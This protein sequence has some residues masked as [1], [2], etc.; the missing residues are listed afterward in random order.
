M[1]FRTLTTALLAATLALTP[2]YTFSDVSGNELPDFGDSSGSL[3]TPAQEQELGKAFMRSIRSQATLVSDPWINAYI[4]QLGARLVAASDAPSYPFTFFV[5]ADPSI[6]AFA[7]PGGYIGIH[8][9]LILAARNESELAGVMAH[10]IAHVTQRHLLR[11]YES[12]S[13]MSLPT[14]AGMLA[15]LLLGVATKDAGAGIAAA[16]AVQAGNIQHQLNFTRANEKEADRIG[17]QTL[18]RSGIDPFGMPSFFERLHQSTR[19]YG[20]NVPEFL[21]THPVTSNRIAE[22]MSRAEK[23]GRGK[24]RDSLE[25]D[26]EQARLKVLTAKDPQLVLREYRALAA[27]GDDSAAV[28]YALALANW[29]TGAPDKAKKLLR[30]LLKE[31]PDRSLY[32]TTLAEI[33]LETGQKQAALRRL[34]D[35]LS[36]YPGDLV[37][38]QYYASALIQ[39]GHA[40]QARKQLLA[41]L[42]NRNAR[43]T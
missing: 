21:S 17:I 34:R 40:D 27:K 20:N 26:L 41:M 19:L 38:G 2:P 32:R 31:D 22:A 18:G 36:L 33:E 8:T 15:A 7:G 23:I 35:T 14:A 42:R 13:Q 30:S 1:R 24:E 28:R 16:S 11:A 43:T 25:F 39:T 10:E 12:A 6:N 5:V 37:V 3:I 29:R 4:R 9:G